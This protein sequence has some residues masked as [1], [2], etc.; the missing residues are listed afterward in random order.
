LGF[1]EQPKTLIFHKH[2]GA[3]D[4]FGI[5]IVSSLMKNIRIY[6]TKMSLSRWYQKI[7]PQRIFLINI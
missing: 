1:G 4:R 3:N 6:Y 2:A 7:T 5:K